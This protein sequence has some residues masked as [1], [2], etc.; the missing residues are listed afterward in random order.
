MKR[1]LR[2]A[3]RTYRRITRPL[4]LR[5]ID[6]QAAASVRE[7]AYLRQLECDEHFY[8]VQLSVRR[9]RIEKGHA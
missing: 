8:Q 5:W 7:L 3:K 6:Y 2:A 1:L 4:R 9:D